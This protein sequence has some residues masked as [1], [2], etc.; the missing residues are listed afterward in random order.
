MAEVCRLLPK[1]DRFLSNTTFSSDDIQK[2]IENLDSGKAHGHDRIS[3]RILEICG[4]SICKPLE[5]IFKSCSEKGFFPLEW[6]K[7]N[8]VVHKK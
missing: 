3:I 6:K 5:I 8:V 7:A 1:T 4:S 2:I